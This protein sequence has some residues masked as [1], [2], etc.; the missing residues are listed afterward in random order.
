MIGVAIAEAFVRTTMTYD[1][2]FAGLFAGK[3]TP[4][5]PGETTGTGKTTLT[6]LTDKVYTA[7]GGGDKNIGGLK[8]WWEELTNKQISVGGGKQADWLAPGSYKN[9]DAAAMALYEKQDPAAAAEMRARLAAEGVLPEGYKTRQTK[10][11]IAISTPERLKELGGMQQAEMDKMKKD[12]ITGD[13]KQSDYANRLASLSAF[14]TT[15]TGWMA[16]VQ[17]E[18][19]KLE[20]SFKSTGDAYNKFLLIM[21][22]GNQEAIKGINSLIA[23]QTN[24][25]DLIDNWAPSTEGY[26]FTANGQQFDNVTNKNEAQSIASGLAVAIAAAISSASSNAL[27]NQ[28]Q[29]RDVYGGNTTPTSGKDLATVTQDAVKL[30]AQYYS[31]LTQDEM[32]A[33]QESFE[34]F[35][36]WVEDAGKKF[37]KEV[38]DSSG[39]SIDKALFGEAF[40]KAQEE[41][42][43]SSKASGI[44]WQ[45]STATAAQIRAAEAQAPAFTKNLQSMGVTGL[46][47]LQETVM[48][49]SEK[50]TIVAHGDQKVIS[51]LLQQIL[52][53]EKKQLQ[54]IY[55][56]PEGANIMVP[57][58][59]YMAGVGDGTTTPANPADTFSGEK[60][61]PLTPED[62]LKP[63][64]FNNP[65]AMG[66]PTTVNKAVEEA[67][68]AP[69]YVKA[70]QW[71]KDKTPT[72][73][74]PTEG[75]GAIEQLMNMLKGLFSSTGLKGPGQV[76]S[77]DLMKGAKDMG[78]TNNAP[79]TSTR[80]DIKLTSTTNLMVDGRVLASIVKPYLASDLLKT[81]QSGGTVTRQYVI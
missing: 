20:S 67:V 23:E 8:A 70:D 57:F 9:K 66:R 51:Y 79:V 4:P 37:Y 34:K 76:G 24:L 22:S 68:T 7:I 38:T 65:H 1:K 63:S 62:Y 14:T 16:A 78:T 26:S 27:L 10:E 39:K 6:E 41:G 49:T 40:Q 5:E 33:K 64:G 28:I 58:Q 25:Q 11:Q 36:V 71:W 32:A 53:T 61:K 72:T 75:T 2:S 73:A 56:L 54:G 46:D 17:D 12:V 47:P 43:I 80:M 52:D 19:G 44:D 21:G 60:A 77:F 3:V 31:N 42:R 13:M 30:Q 69:S 15:A 35:Y 18:S 55:N 59:G 74:T 45:V 29:T 50:Q 81:N 48:T